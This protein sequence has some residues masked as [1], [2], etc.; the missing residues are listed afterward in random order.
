VRQQAPQVHGLGQLDQLGQFGRLGQ[1]GRLRL[2][3]G[4]VDVDVALLH[5]PDVV[6]PVLPLGGGAGAIVVDKDG[7][8]LL[9]LLELC[10][11][12]DIVEGLDLVLLDLGLLK[13]QIDLEVIDVVEEGAT[14]ILQ[15]VLPQTLVLDGDVLDVGNIVES[16]FVGVGA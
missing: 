8:P 3:G 13:P 4:C 7:L 2:A 6:L 1:L 11:E 14:E 9:Q 12:L 10:P 5:T 16:Q 15:L